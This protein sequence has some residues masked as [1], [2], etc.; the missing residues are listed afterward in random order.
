MKVFIGKYV[1]YIGPYQLADLLQYVGVSKDRCFKIGEWLAETWVNDVCQWVE[2]KKKRNVHI[3]IDKYDTWSMDSTLAMIVVP[4]LKQL[5]ETKHGSPF[6]DD[7]DV[8][9][10]LRSTTAQPPK[11]NEWDTDGNF[12]LRWDYVMDEMV[13]A[14]EQ[15]LP[16]ANADEKFFGDGRNDR[17]GY[18]AHE[19][20]VTNG[21]RLFGKYYRG[22][23][24]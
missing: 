7:E 8:P 17:E 6:V 11:Q 20:R 9:E 12:H 1:N 14:F 3:R 13:W 19:A 21:L 24:D 10:H 23:W 18:E 5:H 4:M 2:S 22:L 15:C 16:D